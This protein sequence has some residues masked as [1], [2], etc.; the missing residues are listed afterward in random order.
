VPSRTPSC[1]PRSPY[2]LALVLY[3]GEEGPAEDNELADVLEAVTWLR[4][5]ELAVVLEPTDGEVQ[6]GCLGGIHAEL[7]FVG[8]RPT[9][10]ARGTART[11]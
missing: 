10:P 7:T 6:V 11:R 5:A 3:A 4:D 8:R 2:D 1:A 9:R